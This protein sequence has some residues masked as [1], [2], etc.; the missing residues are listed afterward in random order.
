MIPDEA[1]MRRAIELA[2]LNFRQGGYAVGAVVVRGSTIIAEAANR[3]VQNNDPTA[4]AEVEAIRVACRKMETRYLAGCYLY[5]TY[6]PCP[7]CV[8]AAIWAKMD[9]I[10]YGATSEDSTESHRWRVKI[11]AEEVVAKG[12]PLLALYGGFFRDECKKLLA[13]HRG[14]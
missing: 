13:L 11:S 14:A 9:G 1:I 4:H 12:E 8:S 7:M 6:E 10:V 2:E 5:S 3:A